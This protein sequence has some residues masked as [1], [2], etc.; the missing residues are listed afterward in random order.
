MY[1]AT[2]CLGLVCLGDKC[3]LGVSVWG[4]L[5]CVG[6]SFSGG[7]IVCVGGE[8][9]FGVLGASV[10]EAHFSLHFDGCECW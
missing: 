4:G 9:Y 6:G 2:L 3:V 5:V 7:A 8:G 1:G 10:S